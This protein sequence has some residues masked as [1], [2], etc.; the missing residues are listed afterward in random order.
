MSYLIL[1]RLFLYFLHGM[2]FF[3]GKLLVPARN[4]QKWSTNK[5]TGKFEESFKKP[6]HQHPGHT[7][8]M[9]H[10]ICVSSR[11][12]RLLPVSIPSLVWH[13]QNAGITN[14]WRCQTQINLFLI[15]KNVKCDF[16]AMVPRP[17]EG[18]RWLMPRGARAV[19]PLAP[20]GSVCICAFLVQK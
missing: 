18:V 14:L 10:I 2:C 4:R 3:F 20:S 17:R 19:E 11:R 16:L 15:T 8:H 9:I 7:C 1:Y 5:A 6:C 12:K 13:L